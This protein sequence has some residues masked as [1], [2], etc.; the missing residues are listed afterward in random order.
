MSAEFTPE[1]RAIIEGRS[2]NICEVCGSA[3]AWDS[4]HRRP[5]MAGGT[6]RADVGTAANALHTCRMC[7][8]LI[9]SH[10][11]LARLLGWLVPSSLSPEACPVVYRGEWVHLDAGGSIAPY[12]QK[13]S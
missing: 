5:R 8:N 9:E 7:H 1:V 2:G 6:R 10:R 11:N 13:A 3:R 12:E 4:H